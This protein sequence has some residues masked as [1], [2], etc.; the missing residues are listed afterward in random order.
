M[1]LNEFDLLPPDDKV[2]TVLN[3]TI[4][5]AF[6]RNEEIWLLYS[7]DTFYVEMLFDRKLCR[8]TEIRIVENTEA[9]MPYVRNVNIN[10]LLR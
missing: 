9:L 1:H 7:L 4:L 8:T 5:A 2:V 6:A 10:G 3:G